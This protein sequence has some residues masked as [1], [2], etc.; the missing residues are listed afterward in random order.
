MAIPGLGN[1]SLDLI[2][3]G[4]LKKMRIY[5]YPDATFSG[6]VSKDNIVE[7]LINPESYTK[8]YKLKVSQSGQGQ[9]TSGQELKY[10]YTEPAEMSFEFLFDCTGIIDGQPNK[11]IIE[12]LDKFKKVLTE[13]K[14]EHH[15]PAHHKLVWGSKDGLFKGRLVNLSINYKLFSSDGRPLRA[16]AKA[17]FKASI[18]EEERAARENRT[19]PDLTHLRIVKHGDTLPIMCKR[20]YGDPKYYLQ[21]AGFNRLGNFRQLTP[22]KELLFPPIKKPT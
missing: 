15:Q 13:F 21:V 19:S 11:D 2:P 4:E 8:E 18:A 16:I 1:V 17:T 10:E 3:Y 5:A 9:G 14:G 22:G 20:I 6:E 12:Q 7:V